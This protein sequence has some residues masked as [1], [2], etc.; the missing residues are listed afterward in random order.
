MAEFNELIR[1]FDKIRDYIRDFYIYGFKS[2]TD[3]THKSARTYD[4][5]RRRIE[6]YMGEYMKWD[7]SKSGKT[8]FISMDCAKVPVNPLYAAWKSKAFTANDIMLHFY[9]LDIM[10]VSETLSLED[11][12]DRICGRSGQTFEIQTV[13]NKCREY[14]AMG[15][16]EVEKRGKVFFYKRSAKTLETLAAI[17]PNL[18]EAVKFFQGSAL[19]GEIGSFILDENQIKNDRFS[20]QHN[21]VAHTL[22]DGILLELLSCIRKGEAIAF[23]NYSEKRKSTS[24]I[25]GI[26]LKIL[27][28]ASTGRRYLCLY[29]VYQRRFTTY[30]LDHI[31]SVT[32]MGECPEIME[33]REKLQKNIDRVWGVGFGGRSRLEVI[34][35]KLYIREGQEDFILERIRRE[36]KGGE[37]LRLEP[38]IYLYTKEVYDASEI[39]P[40]IKTFTGRIIQLEGTNDAVISRF[41][42]DIDRM[43]AIYGI[44]GSTWNY[45]QKSTD[46]IT[47]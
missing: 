19:F 42:N 18:P 6:S 30:R 36:G 38:D 47:P 34:C 28:S 40:W 20:F 39:S 29:R 21:Y 10:N 16:L 9:I 22:E 27:I 43:K 15:M 26:P 4:N 5:E 44:E 7:Y 35:M 32:P 23:V 41:Y 25:E 13:R 14:A 12:T 3:F 17:A 1:N 2:R 46:V 31:K 11:L 45:S 24:T 33:Y 8:A 37:L